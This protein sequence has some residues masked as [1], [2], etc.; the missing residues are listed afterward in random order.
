M[1]LPRALTTAALV[2]ALSTGPAP[3]QQ[4]N[5]TVRSTHGDWAIRCAG[6]RGVCVMQTVG[7]GA[8]GNDVLE[9]RIRKLDDVRTQE[10]QTVPAAIQIATPLGVLLRAGVRVQ[11]DGGQVRTGLYEICLPQACIVRDLVPDE[12]LN[13]MRRGNIAK[14]TIVSPAQGEVSIDVS[15]RGFTAAFDA[16]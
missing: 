12:F 7:K 2:F 5:E 6:D 16:L 3:A 10:G 14:M 13:A 4:A 8:D 11:V 15:L 9:I 1:R